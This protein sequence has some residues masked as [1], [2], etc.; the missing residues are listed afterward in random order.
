MNSL[1]F[2]AIDFETATPERHSICEIG[3]A[4]VVDSRIAEVR[5]WLVRPEANRYHPFNIGV[6]GITPEATC[7]APDF[8]TLWPTVEPY[9]TDKVVVAHN[10]AFDMSVLRAA[11]DRSA[12]PYPSLSHYCSLRLARQTEALQGC[13]DYRLGTL[14]DTLGIRLTRHHRAGD[15]AAACAALFLRC[16]EYARTASWEELQGKYRFRCGRFAAPDLFLPQRSLRSEASDRKVRR[17]TPAHT[18]SQSE[19]ANNKTDRL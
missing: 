3:L 1:N 10:S 8:R 6:H 15:D 12:L 17:T 14:C 2:V 18:A 5:S 11:L 19:T 4:T 13:S 16:I 7:E 9:L